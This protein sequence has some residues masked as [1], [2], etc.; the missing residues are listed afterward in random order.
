MNL[1]ALRQDVAHSGWIRVLLARGLRRLQILLGMEIFRVNVR[2]IPADAPEGAPPAGIRLCLLGLDQLLEAAADPEL[3]LEPAFVRAT[4]SRGDISFGAYDGDRLVG[5][6]FRTSTAAPLAVSLWVRIGP[7]AHHVHKT[8][9]R[10]SHRGRRIHIAM[11]RFADRHSLERGCP[12]EIGFVN[13]ANLASLGAARSI[14][15]TKVGYAGFVTLFGHAIPF[16]TPGVRDKGIVV[17][18]PHA[19][20]PIG[21]V[22]ER[23]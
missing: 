3:E 6:S 7:R 5:Y 10:P 14:G 8:F 15:R 23:T 17:F 22:P 9:I 21:L 19:R 1:H 2:P 13:I 4:L 20:I 11:T 18:E 16:R 12:A